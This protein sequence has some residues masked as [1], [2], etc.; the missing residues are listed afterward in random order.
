MS[1]KN[2]FNRLS[3]RIIAPVAAIILLIGIGLYL[4]VLGSVSDFVDNLIQD[5]VIEMAHDLYAICE[6]NLERPGGTAERDHRAAGEQAKAS[7]LKTIEDFARWNNIQILVRESGRKLFQTSGYPPGHEGEPGAAMKG[8]VMAAVHHKGIKYYLFRQYFK[9]WDWEIFLMRSTAPYA[10]FLN[11]LRV[12]Y[13][14]TG[15]MLFVG[16]VVLLYYLK[17]TIRHPL[18]R[19]IGPLQRDEYPDYKGIHEFAFL[20]DTIRTMMESIREESR[21]LN[22]IYYIAA[23]KRGED[24]FNEVVM[25][26]SR[27]FDLHAFIARL[28]P[29]LMSEQVVA[30]YLNGELKKGMDMP[31]EGTPCE[32]VIE[33]KHMC[34]IEKG[35]YREF[36]RAPLLT[37]NLV[38]SFIGFAIFNRKQ[39][40]IGVVNAFGRERGF[41]E[42]DI[43]VL[44]TI[45]QMVAAEME[46][47]GEEREK[48]RLR[49]Q[50]FQAQKMEA[51]GTL[52]GGIAHDFNNILQGI[53]GYASFL[54]TK[55]S[56]TDQ[57]Y[58]PLEVIEQLS[59][60]AADL[61]KQLLGFAGKGKYAVKPLDLNEAVNNVLKIIT[62]TFD[63][64]IEIRTNV[65]RDLW[66][67]EADKGQ[68][69]H[70][71]LNLCLNAR[72]AMPSG[73]TLLIQT[74]NV[75]IGENI[76][77]YPWLKTG[78]YVTVQVSDTGIGMDEEVQR[79]AF[80]PFFTTKELG[81]GTGM[82]LAMVYGV[83]KNHN[84]NITLESVVGKGS[85]FTMY[86]QAVEKELIRYIPL[87]KN[88]PRGKG[89]ILVVDDEEYIR[90]I[91]KDI[92]QGLGY[93]VLA[94]ASGIEA[95]EV[96]KARRGEIDLIILDFI[97]PHMG[98]SETLKKLKALDPDAK[99]LISS[100]YGVNDEIVRLMNTPGVLGFIQKPYHIAEIAETLKKALPSS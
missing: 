27:L 34:V 12:G 40:V 50:V 82:G 80:E 9:S 76:P 41:S 29:D 7:A 53:L 79:H 51:V 66:T 72:D 62:R 68:I 28:N 46:R 87:E 57:L 24:F 64:A 11:L 48:E 85:T 75:E 58:K 4:F 16:M 98:G 31:L 25:A 44:Q 37:D 77:R 35:A 60:S 86:L 69:E 1:V 45:G 3:F 33:R 36:P 94:A 6:D 81:R 97:M 2:I 88:V 55:I 93:R 26:I 39:E 61:T 43:K 100:G 67:V 84:G 21:M 90:D 15:S 59:E 38:E 5:S 89:T 18:D 99:V 19:I 22:I 95:L 10:A 96:F 17:R 8:E 91:A 13:V 74:A 20:S 32:G 54:K 70:S 42:S 73:G 71:I 56:E 92:L 65:A 49:D 78:R 30:M 83:V 14:I 47:L 23:S 52:A 63:R